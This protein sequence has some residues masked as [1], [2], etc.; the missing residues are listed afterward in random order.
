MK[1]VG[2]LCAQESARSY[3]KKHFD[4][5]QAFLL[6]KTVTDYH[7]TP[8]PLPTAVKTAVFGGEKV[9]IALIYGPNVRR[10]QLQLI[11]LQ[12]YNEKCEVSMRD[13]QIVNINKYILYLIIFWFSEAVCRGQKKNCFKSVKN[14]LTGYDIIVHYLNIIPFLFF[15]VKIHI[16]CIFFQCFLYIRI[17]NIWI[18]FFDFIFA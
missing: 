9:D 14:I 2:P 16:F 18:F 6:T 17:I 3:L 13:V 1:R 8:T 5:K 4:V 7:T 10:K 12:L 11:F 15:W